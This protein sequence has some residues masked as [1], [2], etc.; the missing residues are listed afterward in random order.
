MLRNDTLPAVV[1]SCYLVIYCIL[2]QFP[3]TFIYS[4]I[5][6]ML[7]PFLLCWLIY[8]ILK[9]GKYSGKELGDEEF[10]YQDTEKDKLGTF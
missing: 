10:G 3:S 7:A 4:F 9:S 1:V 6:L 2:L 5:M 8:T